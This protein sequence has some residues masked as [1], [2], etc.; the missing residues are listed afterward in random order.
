MIDTGIWWTMWN[1]WD[2][3]LILGSDVRELTVQRQFVRYPVLKRRYDSVCTDRS[4]IKSLARI[5]KMIPHVNIFISDSDL[6]LALQ[7][8][9]RLCLCQVKRRNCNEQ[10]ATQKGGTTRSRNHCDR[11]FL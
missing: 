3:P 1:E 9:P 2:K 11:P 6:A 8:Q 4:S 7:R 10:C 5:I